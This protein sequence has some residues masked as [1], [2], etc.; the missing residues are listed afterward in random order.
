MNREGKKGTI[1]EKGQDTNKKINENER[2]KG[3]KK[4]E[5]KQMWKKEQY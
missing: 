3:N 5:I 4:R 2:E 1:K